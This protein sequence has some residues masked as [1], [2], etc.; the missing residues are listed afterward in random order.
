MPGIGTDRAPG[1]RTDLSGIGSVAPTPAP[2]VEDLMAAYRNGVVT[3]DDINRRLRGNINDSAATATNVQANDIQR[4]LAPGAEANAQLGQQVQAEELKGKLATVPKQSTIASQI[5]QDEQDEVSPDAAVRQQAIQRKT[6]R[7]YQGLFGNLPESVPVPQQVKPASFEDWFSTVKQPENGN[8]AVNTPGTD[9]DR[10][11]AFNASQAAKNSPATQ[12]EYQ[13]YVKEATNR[14]TLIPK[15]DPEYYNALRDQIQ[16]KLTGTAVREAQVKAIPGV[17]EAQAKAAAS[18]PDKQEARVK[19]L[20]QEI[21][22]DTVLKPIA[23][24]KSFLGNAK[25]ILAKPAN[26]IT[27]ADDQLLVESLIKL[28]DPQG[29]IRQ[30]KVEYLREMTPFLQRVEKDIQRVYSTQGG[31]LTAGDRQQIKGAIDTVDQNF[32]RASRDRLQLYNSRAVKSGIPAGDI[33][34][35]EQLSVLGPSAAPSAN[36]APAAGAPSSLESLVGKTIRTKDGRTGVVTKNPD[37]SY[38]L[39]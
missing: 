16:A 20:H 22:N 28:T 6:E 8:T 37:G 32:Q 15:G 36:A 11:A 5:L 4:R 25:S 35:T 38:T 33:F 34:D 31:V 18:E 7:Q 1:L 12:Q 10:A 9:Q 39:K 24:A 30:S 29:V 13:D 19:D 26:Q 27:N 21:Q 17:L 14:A 3:V 23:E 2:G